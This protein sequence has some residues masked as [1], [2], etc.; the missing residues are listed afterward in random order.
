VTRWL[1][2]VGIGEDGWDGLGVEARSVIASAEILV[3]GE[4]HLALVPDMPAEK[5][6]WSRPLS[7]TIAMI[8]GSRG[9]SVVVLASGDPLQ[10]GIGATLLRSFAGDEIRILPAPGAFSLAAGRLGWPLP[11]I[12]CLSLHAR[13]LDSLARHL[14]PAA[15]LL[16]LTDDAAAPGRIAGWLTE[17]GW[18][19]SDVTVLERLGGPAERIVRGSAE[20]FADGPFADLN[21][22]AI[23]CRP[24]ATTPVRSRLAGLPDEAFRHDG[25]LTKAEIRAATLA[26]LAP[27]RGETLWDVGAGCGSIGI[28]W[29]RAIEGGAAHAIECD[30]ARAALIAAN[31]STLGVPELAIV[32]GAAPAALAGLP[33]PDAIFVGGGVDAALLELCH[34]ALKPGGRLVANAVTVEGEATLAQFRAAR[35]GSLTRLAI[36]R[37]EPAGAHL[38]WRALAPVTQLAYR[39]VPD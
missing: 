1:T 25:Q 32:T 9:R 39:K 15:R 8:E 22:L 10:F 36:S 34:H 18:G 7:G 3:G 30:P 23:E 28:E 17:R 16:A 11:E 27:M 21:T 13:P 33:A 26:A 38:I 5:W 37:A 4:R 2:I 31:A 24:A 12:S 14:A 6:V 35:G 19:P 20:A 29:L